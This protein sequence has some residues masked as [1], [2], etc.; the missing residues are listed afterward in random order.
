MNAC[1]FLIIRYAMLRHSFNKNLI[2][3]RWVLFP[4]P[5]GAH[6]GG[7]YLK[8][9]R[10]KMDPEKM[11]DGVFKEINATLKLMGKAKTPEDK[12][13]YSKALKNLCESLNSIISMIT[14]TMPSFMDDDFDDDFDDENDFTIPF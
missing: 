1:L 6:Q 2:P 10:L 12:L 8:K 3:P 7:F 14:S 9:R 4:V 13:T 5:W 11:I